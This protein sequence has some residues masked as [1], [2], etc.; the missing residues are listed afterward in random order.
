MR[1][2]GRVLVLTE[3]WMFARGS[4]LRGEPDPKEGNMGE[5]LSIGKLFGS[6]KPVHIVGPDKFYVLKILKDDSK[7]NKIGRPELIGA[8][9]H[10]DPWLC[11]INAIA[12]LMLL[13]FGKDGLIAMPDFFDAYNDWPSEHQFLTDADGWNAITYKNQTQLFSE[14]KSAAGM[15]HLMDDSATKLRSWGAM[16]ASEHQVSH[17]EVERHGRCA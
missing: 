3:L 1:A 7:A 2:Q 9:R 8:T 4:D 16:A 13:R 10:R 17:A 6:Y 5:M 11:S 15:M 12:S 14:M